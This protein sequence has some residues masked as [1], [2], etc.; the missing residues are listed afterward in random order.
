MISKFLCLTFG[1]SAF[2]AT[3]PCVYQ[4]DKM[5]CV[6]SINAVGGKIF[7][8]KMNFSVYGNTFHCGGKS[9]RFEAQ[10]VAFAPLKMK[11]KVFA[12]WDALRL[13]IYDESDPTESRP[14]V[15]MNSP[16]VQGDQTDQTLYT[17]ISSLQ[18][19]QMMCSTVQRL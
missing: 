4:E 9:D 5:E 18:Y 19:V 17:K 15:D 12:D 3:P 6:I 13:S 11:A 1:F 7:N 14:L 10:A 2:A 16:R 8:N